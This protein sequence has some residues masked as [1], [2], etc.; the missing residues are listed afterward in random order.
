[1]SEKRMP[2]I[3]SHK[4]YDAVSCGGRIRQLSRD[5][6]AHQPCLVGGQACTIGYRL[7]MTLFSSA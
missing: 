3:L 5:Q 4:H 7:T 2:P 6:G 1:M